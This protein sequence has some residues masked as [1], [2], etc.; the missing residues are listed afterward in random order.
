M[1]SVDRVPGEKDRAVPF[2]TFAYLTAALY[3]IFGLAQI[4]KV[5]DVLT[6]PVSILP[7]P[8]DAIG[9]LVLVIIGVI[10]FFGAVKHGGSINEGTSFILVAGMIGSFFA[11]VYLLVLFSDLAE[12][13]ILVNE[14]FEHWTMVDSIRPGIYLGLL[15]AL[16][17]YLSS[18]ALRGS[19]GNE[20][21]RRRC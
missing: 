12:A 20:D 7:I 2:R 14:D 15:S 11:V 10:F 8:G 18:R 6:S 16:H 9:G 19:T 17:L 3:V 21:E 1:A 5:F 4:I 13:E